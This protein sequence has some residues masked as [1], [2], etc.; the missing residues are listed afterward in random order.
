MFSVEP[1]AL[2][3][4][5]GQMGRAGDDATSIQTY[6]LGY[7]VGGG[8]DGLLIEAV[9]DSHVRSMDIACGLSGRV[10][11]VLRDSQAGLLAPSCSPL[12]VG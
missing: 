3:G 4:Y 9:G 2:D 11:T 7:K 10:A 5:A 6:L 12:S 8:W 1:A